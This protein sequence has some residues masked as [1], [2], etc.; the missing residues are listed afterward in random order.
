A[1]AC[2]PRFR[3]RRPAAGA[4]DVSCQHGNWPP[5]DHCDEIDAAV[6]HA[7]APLQAEIE[8]L[9]AERDAAFRMSRCECASDECCANLVKHQQRAERLAEAGRRV[10]AA[11]RA[12]GSN[13]TPDGGRTRAECEAAMLA[14]DAALEQEA[15][16]G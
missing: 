3:P 15:G 4:D 9:R 10:T 2:V 6:A 1:C 13:I 7:I 12:H 14:L 11:F 8:A 5:C 16:R